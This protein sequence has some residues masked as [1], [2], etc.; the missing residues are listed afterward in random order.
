[1]NS[2]FDL[3]KLLNDKLDFYRWK[4]NIETLNHEYKFK[5]IIENLPYREALLWKKN[6][7]LIL[8]LNIPKGCERT[9]QEKCIYRWINQTYL[10]QEKLPQRYRYSSGLNSSYGY[11]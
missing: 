7:T 3:P 9:Y 11:K 10:Y 4:N 1:M 6:M 8:R 2:H 5:T